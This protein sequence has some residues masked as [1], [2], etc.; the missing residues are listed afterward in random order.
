MK[1]L[2]LKLQ[3]WWY[4]RRPQKRPGFID[5]L[6]KFRLA[7]AAQFV[8]KA[9][10]LW[11]GD[12][13]FHQAEP[14]INDTPGWLCL[15]VSGSTADPDGLKY[16]AA[17]TGIVKPLATVIDW[18]GNDF[19]QGREVKD[20]LN[21]HLAVRGRIAMQ[22]GFVLSLELCPLGLPADN[23]VNVKIARF[24]A[25]LAAAIG[26]DFVPVNDKLAPGGTMLQKYDSGDHIHWSAAAFEDAV[27]PRVKEAL[28]AR[29]IV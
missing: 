23:P 14:Q 27:F 9:S 22:G 4:K 10:V 3:A 7:Q 17:L 13:R 15:A 16:G 26:P 8:G 18:D 6:F 25:A 29:G 21:A 19:L 28:K 11:S 1:K 24:N 5:L 12:S 2:I 20:V